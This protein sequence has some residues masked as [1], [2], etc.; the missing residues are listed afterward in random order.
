MLGFFLQ[1]RRLQEKLLFR[2]PF[3]RKKIRHLRLALGDRAGLVE[4]DDLRSSEKLQR[5]TGFKKDSVPGA[6]SVSD[7]D[8]HGRRESQRAGAG[9][10]KDGN[11]ALQ[12]KGKVL[13]AEY[14]PSE[15]HEKRNPDDRRNKYAGNPVRYPCDRGL[16][17]RR[18]RNHLNDFGERRIL[19][20]A[21]R[22]AAKIARGVDRCRTDRAARLLIDGNGF[23][24]ER[25]LVDRALALQHDAVH[26]DRFSGPDREDI[27]G[28]HLVDADLHFLAVPHE[29]RGFRRQL[30]QA[31]QRVRRAAL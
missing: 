9:N 11:C 19:S 16:G 26:R 25:R 21:R 22:P 7:H 3:R 31:L 10:Y 2:H 5:F 17:R 15:E 1:R 28:R 4:N 24:G 30:H 23:S 6:E 12:R 27:A 14:Q 18:V 8:R 20:D 13:V 29:N